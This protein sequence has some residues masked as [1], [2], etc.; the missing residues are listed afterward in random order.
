MLTCM[1]FMN[2]IVPLWEHC[3]VPCTRV[4][5]D[6]GMIIKYRHNAERRTML[7][8]DFRNSPTAG[9]QTTRYVHTVTYLLNIRSGHE[10]RA[11]ISSV[12]L[13]LMRFIVAGVKMPYIMLSDRLSSSHDSFPRQMAWEDEDRF[14][15]PRHWA[16]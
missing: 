3:I 15:T 1:N 8:G 4:I 12:R 14:C 13:F 11:S 5:R 7:R 10:A 16:E 9:S 6:V 2:T